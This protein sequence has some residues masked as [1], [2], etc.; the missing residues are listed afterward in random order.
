MLASSPVD[1]PQDHF[2]I[3]DV[4]RHGFTPN[5]G[6]FGDVDTVKFRYTRP[7]LMAWFTD[8]EMVYRFFRK[9]DTT[10]P[11]GGLSDPSNLTTDEFLDHPI[12][13]LTIRSN[14]I[15]KSSSISPI[16]V[17]ETGYRT[18]YFIGRNQDRWFTDVPCFKRVQYSGVYPGIDLE[19]YDNSSHLEFDFV[20]MPG[21]DIQQIEMKFTGVDSISLGDNGDLLIATEWGS[22]R[23]QRPFIYKIEGDSKI[24]VEGS[25]RIISR[26]SFGFE[27]A[28]SSTRDFPI[29]IDPI[30]LYS[31]YLGGSSDEFEYGYGG[32]AIAQ[33]FHGGLFVCGHTLSD[34][35]PTASA[36][37]DEFG[38]GHCDAFITK[39][40]SDGSGL[41]FS[42][43]IGG[44]DYDRAFG[45]ACDSMGNA[46]IAGHTNSLD[47]PIMNAFQDYNRAH[48]DAFVAKLT[49]TGNNLIYCSYFGGNSTETAF[50]IAVDPQ[51]C[52]YITGWTQST[53][54]FRTTA[55]ILPF[56][57]YFDAFVAKVDAAG[58]G[59]VYGTYI[60][61]TDG[62]YSYDISCDDLGHAF[63]TGYT[64]S[65][66]FTT[67]NAFESSHSGGSD[68]FCTRIAADGSSIDFSSYLGG[69]GSDRGWTI[70][71]SRDGRVFIAGVT[72]SEDFPVRDAYQQ[73]LSGSTDAFVTQI[74]GDG[75]S[76]LLSTFLGG[77]GDDGAY[78]IATDRFG[79]VYVVGTT[80]SSDFP[81]VDP[82]QP[83]N[84]GFADAFVSKLDP[85]S[86]TLQ[87]ST[88]IGGSEME[89]GYDIAVG[90]FGEMYLAGRTS[91]I[92]FPISG[93]L[94]PDNN[95]N[96]DAFVTKIGEEIAVVCGDVNNSSEVDIDDIVYF[97][98]WV[99]TGGVS[100]VSFLAADVN[101][102]GVAD[103]DDIVY[104]VTYIFGGG[105]EPCALC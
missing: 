97:V 63:I 39:V 33:D 52:A 18:N 31:F 46:Y 51:R 102:D 71:S 64:V 12:E 48:F 104:L 69:S 13:R 61:G 10:P 41:Q 87:F 94:G 92:D 26:S 27:L 70:E 5:V 3:S 59:I 28:D 36:D 40:N 20:V 1:T 19:F 56:S 60:G 44:S 38:G 82:V 85:I 29:V 30:L 101:C 22:I 62:D 77:S 6:Q 89:E 57:G 65:A 66:D 81:T 76:I 8:T 4:P 90:S 16:G 98:S 42:S 99:F 78:G 100:P 9:T 37:Q 93:P 74:P 86:S 58:S 21:A 34:D 47:F 95:G 32:G 79:V 73:Y 67:V 35:F 50:G 91:S 103:I 24:E 17:D 80:C 2:S 88:F 72:G 75:T 105:P 55:P 68:A 7:G 14:L 53:D 23:K 25:Y 43:Y 49:A 83:T 11:N 15:G 45:V 96:F 54:L 84:A